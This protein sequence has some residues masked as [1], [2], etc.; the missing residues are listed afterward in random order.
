MYPDIQ[1]KVREEVNQV[2]GTSQNIEEAHLQQL[3][4]CK[5]VL[6]ETLRLRPP[7][8]GTLTQRLILTFSGLTRTIE[9]DTVLSGVCIPK[10]TTVLAYIHAAHVH[11]RYWENPR[12]YRPERWEVRKNIFSS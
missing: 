6:N 1:A 10:G 4:Y 7:V 12:E 8:T 3:V 2:M 5:N 9:E 11:P